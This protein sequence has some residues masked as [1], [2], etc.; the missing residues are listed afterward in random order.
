MLIFCGSANV[1]PLSR[2]FKSEQLDRFCPNRRLKDKIKFIRPFE[3][4]QRNVTRKNKLIFM[5]LTFLE[6]MGTARVKN[7]FDPLVLYCTLIL[8]HQEAFEL[9]H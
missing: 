5:G 7:F 3:V 2:V 4:S 6:T 8:R 1:W 9:Y